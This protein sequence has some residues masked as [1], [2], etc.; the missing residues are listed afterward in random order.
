ML[1][2]KIIRTDFITVLRCHACDKE[3]SDYEITSYDD[4]DGLCEECYS[5]AME[6]A[7]DNI[8]YRFEDDF[9]D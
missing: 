5:Q 4:L 6:A 8:E 1:T 2:R 9:N 7:Y 3:L